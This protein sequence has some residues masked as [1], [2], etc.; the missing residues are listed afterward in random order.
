M[1]WYEETNDAKKKELQSVDEYKE[2]LK[3]QGYAEGDFTKTL[4]DLSYQWDIVT[5]I[6][7]KDAN[8]RFVTIDQRI[9][10]GKADEMDGSFKFTEDGTYR[11]VKDVYGY[12]S[13]MRNFLFE[14]KSNEVTIENKKEDKKEDKTTATT[15]NFANSNNKEERKH[16]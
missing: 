2:Y 15:S 14:A 3:E 5:K 7:K 10:E 16:K 9:N 13:S 12:M 4:K 11:V 8:G 6:Q 1:F